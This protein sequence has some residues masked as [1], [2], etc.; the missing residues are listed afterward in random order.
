MPHTRTKAARAIA[1]A[2]LPI[3][4]QSGELTEAKY[5][6]VAL[7]MR[8]QREA[9][10]PLDDAEKVLEHAKLGAELSATS[11]MHYQRAH[12]AFAD[13]AVRFNVPPSA[14]GDLE[15]CKEVYAPARGQAGPELKVV[16][17]GAA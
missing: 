12:K 8:L 10:V 9:R 7:L 6:L 2:L 14:Y 17:A 4:R 16:I 3:E 13:L 1:E 5:R 15:D 11:D